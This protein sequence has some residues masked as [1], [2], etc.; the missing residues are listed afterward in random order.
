MKK[1]WTLLTVS[2]LVVILLLTVTGCGSVL[3]IECVGEYSYELTALT[4]LPENVTFGGT[5][6]SGLV[7]VMEEK[8]NG[9]QYS[10]YDMAAN[11][12][13]ADATLDKTSEDVNQSGMIYLAHGVFYSKKT[14]SDGETEVTIYTRN[15]KREIGVATVTD[16]IVVDKDGTRIYVD[17][18]GELQTET[19]EFKKL[20]VYGTNQVGDYYV[21]GAD[22]FNKDG[23]YLYTI[24]ESILNLPSGTVNLRSWSV[25]NFLFGQGS[26]RLPDDSEEYDYY[27]SNA[28]YDLLTYRLDLSCGKATRV[29]MDYLVGEVL[30]AINDDCVALRVSAIENNRIM[31]NDVAQIF[32]TDGKVAVNLQSM[33]P[34]AKQVIVQGK[35]LIIDDG[36][37]SFLYEGKKRLFASESSCT[38]YNYDLVVKNSDTSVYVYDLKENLIKK[39]PVKDIVDQ[40]SLYNGDL[41]YA[42][43]TEILILHRDTKK[44]ITVLTL[45]Q[46]AMIVESSPYY[47]ETGIGG[48]DGFKCTVHFIDEA[49]T[50]VEMIG[51]PIVVAVS[52]GAGVDYRILKLL[53]PTEDFTAAPIYYLIKTTYPTSK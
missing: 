14:N 38:D 30:T 47:L 49:N 11:A 46:D 53:K 28:K 9:T 12:F 17:L 26:L 37:N 15:G 40:G 6:D 27:S 3:K 22:V 42:T 29:D 16:G 23:K 5:D 25:G 31:K 43:E 48:P 20:A 50:K 36:Q 24:T 35:Y 52:E 32:G 44:A 2:V 8:K 13:V 21:Q 34:G 45:E 33:V 39:L 41:W 18:K 51:D 4:S 19:D 10:L 7:V 1:P